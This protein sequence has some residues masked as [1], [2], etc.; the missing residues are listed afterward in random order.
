MCGVLF[1]CVIIGVFGVEGGVTVCGRCAGAGQ[2]E[3]EDRTSLRGVAVN[4]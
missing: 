3:S 4:P 1:F 2:G